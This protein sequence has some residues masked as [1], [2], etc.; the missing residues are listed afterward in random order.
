MNNIFSRKKNSLEEIKNLMGRLD[1]SYQLITESAESDKLENIRDINIEKCRRFLVEMLK[2]RQAGS[3]AG[4][5]SGNPDDYRGTPGGMTAGMDDNGRPF[6]QWPDCN[7][8]DPGVRA[9]WGSPILLPVYSHYYKV[10]TEVNYNPGNGA[11]RLPNGKYKLNGKAHDTWMQVYTPI[12]NAIINNFPCSELPKINGVATYAALPF[13]MSSFFQNG[14]LSPEAV[15]EFNKL[16][17]HMAKEGVFT[18]NIQELMERIPRKGKNMT[19]NGTKII[20]SNGPIVDKNGTNLMPE[21]NLREKNIP[22]NLGLE[23]QLTDSLYN[24]RN[25]FGA[26]MKNSLEQS[27]SD[28]YEKY[29]D[30]SMEPGKVKHTNSGYTIIR[31]DNFDEARKYS[32]YVTWCICTSVGSFD[33]YGMAD[34]QYSG[35]VNG[36]RIYFCLRDDYKNIEEPKD[37]NGN[38]VMSGNPCDD[39]GLS[40]IAVTVW[41]N[42][43]SCNT[44]TTRWNHHNGGSDESMTP[45]ELEEILGVSFYKAFPGAEGDI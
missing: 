44:I 17:K 32:K 43:G 31:I 13:V 5:L 21:I 41:A 40:M 34:A 35:R 8:G 37:E 20:N 36:G 7:V 22:Q 14:L 12:L 3:F 4:T 33:Q 28:S 23:G 42:D 24:I 27:K 15:F 9:F 1:E 45:E 11:E 25:T 2:N 30:A 39:Y 38:A 18:E 6:P 26:S 29:K 19:E 16:V 10:P